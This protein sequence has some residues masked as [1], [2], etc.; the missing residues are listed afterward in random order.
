[1]VFN[2]ARWLL[3]HKYTKEK[4]DMKNLLSTLKYV[5]APALL[6]FP[7]GCGKAKQDVV[8]AYNEP[9]LMATWES[10]C[11]SSSPLKL[12]EKTFVRFSGSDFEKSQT[13]YSQDGCVEPAVEARYKGTFKLSDSTIPE[14]GAKFIDYTYDS[15]SVTALNPKGKEVLETAKLCGHPTWVVGTRVDLTSESAGASCPLRTSPSTS[16]EVYKVEKDSKILYLSKFGWVYSRG[17]VASDRAK[18]LD[19]DTSFSASNHAF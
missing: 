17:K 9:A 6:L 2:V 3:K 15:A 5:L 10:K 19:T 16:Y 11:S 14:S 13:F 18:E 7:L 12:S 4:I 1:M 8:Q